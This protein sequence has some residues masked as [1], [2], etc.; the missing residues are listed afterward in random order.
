MASELKLSGSAGGR[1]I[2]QG[3][4]TIS[5]DQTFTFPDTGGELAT[6]PTGGSVVGY[7]QGVWTPA[8]DT[9]TLNYV[10]EK[11]RWSR[12]G[13][14]VTVWAQLNTF[15]TAVASRINIINLPYNCP[16]GQA[17]GSCFYQYGG[18]GYDTVYVTNLDTYNGGVMQFYKATD[19]SWDS[20]KYSNFTGTF[21]IYLK[22]TYLTDDTTWTP[23]NGATLS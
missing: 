5:T 9:G 13:N 4:D 16:F 21:D 2:V 19:T 7:Q 8:C 12:I 20:L 22:A 18:V 10:T 3:N 6:A 14:E 15:S 23:I 17:A 1:V 11:T